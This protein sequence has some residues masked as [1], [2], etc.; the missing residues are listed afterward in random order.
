ML[1]IFFLYW[2]NFPCR[3]VLLVIFNFSKLNTL[4]S[5]YCSLKCWLIWQIKSIY[6]Y[7]ILWTSCW[8]SHNVSQTQFNGDPVTLWPICSHPDKTFAD[9]LMINKLIMHRIYPEKTCCWFSFVNH[10]EQHRCHYYRFWKITFS[11]SYN[12]LLTFDLF[13]FQ[14]W[15]FH[16]TQDH[17]KYLSTTS[18]CQSGGCQNPQGQPCGRQHWPSWIRQLPGKSPWQRVDLDTPCFF[19]ICL[20]M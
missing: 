11:H 6:M 3:N 20:G 13:Y 7:R 8:W 5:I 17:S 16:F 19:F 15:R 12:W 10:K 2:I 4:A 18:P 9:K 14:W 1:Y